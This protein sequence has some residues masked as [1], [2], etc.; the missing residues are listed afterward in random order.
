VHPTKWCRVAPGDKATNALKVV[1]F[2]LLLAS[3]GVLR[4][5][6][7][8]QLVQQAVNTELAADT[9]DHSCWI[10]HEIDRKPGKTVVQWVAQTS[11]ADVT[12]VMVKNGRHIPVADQ[13]KA[14]ESFVHDSNAQAK[15]REDN[16]HDNDQAASMLKMLPEA[17]LWTM[18]GKN[19]KTT[20][21]HFKPDPKFNPPSR[22]AKVFAAMEGE[23]AVNN[24][25]HRI[26]ELKGHLIHDV[27]F[28]G[29]LFGKLNKGGSFDVQR[30][31]VGPKIWD[32][33]A[34]HIHI[35]GHALIFKTISEEED[36]VKTSWQREPD[37]VSLQQAAQAV[38][39]KQNV[40]NR[41]S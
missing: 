24:Q 38:M 6:D 15:V 31:Q 34:S 30:R 13:R 14:V 39:K 12:R 37:K 33:T 20:T 41:P 8:K 4:A 40:L 2:W 22:E 1:T 18:K 5:Q 27:D 10:F 21:F 29:G 32:I 7:A 17:F 23:M 9:A 25:Q 3:C 19:Q 28:G 35:K 16:Q 36:D 26:Q 11:T